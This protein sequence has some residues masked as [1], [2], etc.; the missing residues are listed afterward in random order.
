MSQSSAITSQDAHDQLLADL[1]A[2][3]TEERQQGREPELEARLRAHPEV[4]EE[5]R[6]LWVVTQLA[7]AFVDTRATGSYV[8]N[9]KSEV[10]TTPKTLAFP[11][12]FGRYELL[13]ELGRGGMGVVYKA[14]QH[15]PERLVAIKMILRGEMA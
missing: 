8:P 3:M 4:A 1:L 14:K 7:G 2:Q 6:S 10:R 13:E 9:Q 5:L 11:K 15:H 12:P